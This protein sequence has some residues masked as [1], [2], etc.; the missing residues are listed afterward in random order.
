MR[1]LSLHL[2]ALSIDRI[3][4]W[5]RSQRNERPDLA[6][7]EEPA[8]ATVTKVKS[9]FRL[10][11]VDDRAASLGLRPGMA[12]A[13]ARA[14]Y[15][16]LDV[17]DADPAGDAAILAGVA[18]WCRLFTPLAALDGGDGTILDIDGSSHLF[19]GEAAL[20][21]AITA[22]L[23]R[24]GFRV[25]GAIADTPGAAWALARYSCDNRRIV[26]P[27]SATDDCARLFSSFPLA[28]LRLNTATIAKLG[29]A[30][31]RRVGDLL[32]RPRAPV[33]A[34]FGHD[35]H[36]RLDE[37]LGQF[38]LPISPRFEAP[39]YMAE[40]RFAEGI[41]RREDIEAT[42]LS[43]CHDLCGLLARHGEGARRLEVALYRVDGIVK[44]LEAGTSH[45]LRDPLSMARLFRERLE[46]AAEDGLDTGYGFEVLRLAALS[47]ERHDEHQP[48]WAG[49]TGRDNVAFCHLVDRLGARFGS[50]RVVRLG[51]ADSHQPERAAVM[52][53]ADVKTGRSYSDPA[54]S[55]DDADALPTRPIR[56]L[57]RPEPIDAVAAVPEGPPLR[58]DWR[59]VTHQVVAVE[60]PERIA[61]DWWRQGETVKRNTGFEA[62]NLTRDYYRAEDADGGRFWLYREGLHR[63]GSA[64]RWYLHGLFA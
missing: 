34:R 17:R 10:Q 32:V 6:P 41:A 38:S 26:P 57:D 59:R 23:G 25:Q 9:A 58:F 53:P 36:R 20:L 16:N 50:T 8:L 48:G 47:A 12:L 7:R 28:A 40:R 64:Q 51:F 30:G 44:H 33:A 2:P 54:G 61:P 22:R 11:S 63:G 43:L 37:L 52:R 4:R 1:Y 31:L 21:D 56:M 62:D 60:G 24:Q 14:M 5:D 3:R 49:D 19:G 45:P 27:G 46:V 15:P 42:I 35:I 13:D 18:D 39:A 29:Q 55:I